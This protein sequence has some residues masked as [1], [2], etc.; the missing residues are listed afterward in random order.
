MGLGGGGGGGGQIVFS[1]YEVMLQK[2][3][4]TKFPS[5]L[6]RFILTTC[7]VDFSQCLVK[8]SPP[9]L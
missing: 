4:K 2:N 7:Q 8:N 3:F 9:C 1:E 6:I 5:L